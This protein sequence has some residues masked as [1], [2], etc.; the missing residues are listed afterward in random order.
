MLTKL[1]VAIG[2]VLLGYLLGSIPTGYWIAKYLKG[3]DIREVGS[4]STGAT[5]V[6]R[7]VGKTAALIVFVVDLTKGM[8]AIALIPFFNQI[9]PPT[10]Q[11]WLIVAVGLAAIIGHSKSIWLNFQGG[12]S[13]AT[14]L[15]VF[16]IINPI[17]ALGCLGV[18]LIVLGISRIVSLSSICGAIALNIFMI[19]LQ[20]PPAYIL[21]GVIAGIYVIWRHQTNIERILAGTEP[22]L[23]EASTSI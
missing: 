4:G 12:K 11:T 9:I 13:V 2:L 3:I 16:L 23:G 10:W 6:L 1:L 21:L 7:S 18:F 15:G 14:S 22:K 8:I 19:T 5:N 20:Q 17:V